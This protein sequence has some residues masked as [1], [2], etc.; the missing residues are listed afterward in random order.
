MNTSLVKNPNKFLTNLIQY[1]MVI[2]YTN[3][4]TNT[5]ITK[6]LPCWLR[7]TTCHKYKF[8]LRF[9]LRQYFPNSLRIHFNTFPYIILKQ[10]IIF[11]FLYTMPTKVQ[12]LYRLFHP[13]VEFIHCGALSDVGHSAF[14]LF[15][16]FL[17]DRL[18]LEIVDLLFDLLA[19]DVKHGLAVEE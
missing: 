3:N 18:L 14:D 17:D 4:M 10:Q 1:N 9:D 16:K 15:E 8:K 5:S 12:Y 2:F 6:E 7:V 11:F 19:V 13:I